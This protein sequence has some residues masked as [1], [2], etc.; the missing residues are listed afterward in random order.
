MS[1]TTIHVPEH[2]YE[3][4]KGVAFLGLTRGFVMAREGAQ[5]PPSPD[6]DEVNLVLD[7]AGPAPV[8]E[9]AEGSARAEALRDAADMVEAR[10]SDKV[11]Q[12]HKNLWLEIVGAIRSLANKAEKSASR[13]R[14]RALVRAGIV[15]ILQPTDGRPV[16]V[17][18][19]LLDRLIDSVDQED[20]S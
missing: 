18:V 20:G 15:D 17:A 4:A 12:P 14:D 8:P 7:A 2:L 19:S 3:W 1:K 11:K 13:K 16:E 10:F 9:A 6:S 5:R